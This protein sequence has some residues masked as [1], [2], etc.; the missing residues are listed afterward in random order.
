M[1]MQYIICRMLQVVTFGEYME[2][3]TLNWSRRKGG[4]E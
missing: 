4:G 2:H 1:G 3:M